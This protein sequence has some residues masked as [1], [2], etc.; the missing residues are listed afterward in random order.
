MATYIWVCLKIVYPQT[1]WLMIIIPIEWLFHWEYTLFSDKPI[2]LFPALNW[3][4]TV[5]APFQLALEAALEEEIKQHI[6]SNNRNSWVS[7]NKTHFDRWHF[8]FLYL[9][10]FFFSQRRD[11]NVWM[12]DLELPQPSAFVHRSQFSMACTPMLV[13]IISDLA[14]P[15]S[16]H[17]LT[18][19]YWVS[20]PCPKGRKEQHTIEK[21]QRTQCIN[22]LIWFN[23]IQS[24]QM[25][26]WCLA[27]FPFGH[28]WSACCDTALC[29]R[30]SRTISGGPSQKGDL[31]QD[32]SASVG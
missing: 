29:W 4:G 2:Y 24:D 21:K 16:A 1:Q 11:T 23:H 30:E 17:W 14:K 18:G 6:S 32:I 9:F 5:S 22:D 26:F 10:L 12:L 31:G 7:T 8:G 15:C 20:S 19:L 28:F 25:H 27:C 13:V 3:H